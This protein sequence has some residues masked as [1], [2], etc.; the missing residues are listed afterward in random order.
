M[1]LRLRYHDKS[2]V[3]STGQMLI[4]RSVECNLVM[5]D[6]LASRRHAM[7]A[8]SKSGAF[9]TDLGSKAG[10]LVNGVP[11]AGA[12]RLASGDVLLLASERIV[13][14]DVNADDEPTDPRLRTTLSPPPYATVPAGFRLAP[15]P[16]LGVPR[17]ERAG[18]E[19]LDDDEPVTGFV[20]FPE[21]PAA[22]SFAPP[23]APVEDAETEAR[24][25]GA[26]AHEPAPTSDVDRRTAPAPVDSSRR[27]AAPLPEDLS[28]PRIG[29]LP[30]PPSFPRPESLRSLAIVAEKA[31]ALHRAEEAER[32]LQRSLLEMLDAARRDELDAAAIELTA[33]LS[34]KLAIAVGAGR[35][36]D[37]AV[38]LYAMRSELM[39]A[40][41]VDLLLDAV[42]KARPI[43]KAAFRK[44]V[45]AAR[46]AAGDAPA[47][48]FVLHRL[49]AV[50]RILDL[51]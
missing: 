41:V 22:P 30:A 26:S 1:A 43:D 4:G 21:P 33:T 5:S 18:S 50:Q 36:F 39:P 20:R 2:F 13:I 47:R 25:R 3:L 40:A 29:K 35:W 23:A 27:P 14:E 15:T 12:C 8:V 48:R 45:A 24:V 16:P 34:A 42:R 28:N 10:V 51:K 6:P 38:E 19:L 49:E 37:L 17:V 7:L 9:V 46:G 31:I 44:Y 32:I 11:I